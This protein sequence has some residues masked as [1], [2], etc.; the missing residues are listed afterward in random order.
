MYLCFLE[1]FLSVSQ[2]SLLE[3]GE[4]LSHEETPRGTQQVHCAS[5]LACRRLGA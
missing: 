3:R 2:E 1:S 4:S 5:R